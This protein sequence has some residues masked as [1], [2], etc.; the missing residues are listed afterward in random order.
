MPKANGI[1]RGEILESIKMNGSTTAEALAK[2]LGISP[3]AVRQHLT[4][5]EAEG[6]IL[7]TPQRRGLG[8]PVHRYRI[9]PRG[10]ESF[11]RDYSGLANSLL[12]E[13]RT[14]QGESAVE[15]LFASRAQRIIEVN[16]RK[17]Q[18]K[19]LADRV[20]LIA[21]IQSEA[22]FMAESRVDGDDIL[23]E[24]HNCAICLVAK[25]HACAC[26]QEFAWIKELV[27]P[28][29]RVEREKHILA[30][31]HTCTYRITPAD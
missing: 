6:L 17:T 26:N 13:L 9:T 27:G 29:A 28:D 1:T 25:Q 23:L 10:D 4:G 22:G 18:N 30:G 14:T 12:D 8:R 31:Q 15:S 20:K 3:V 7:A 16:R 5:L 21:R 11:P 19:P 2:E 24:E